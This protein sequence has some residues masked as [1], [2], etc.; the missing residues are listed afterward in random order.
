MS[1]LSGFEHCFRFRFSPDDAYLGYFA[2]DFDH[3]VQW[4][5]FLTEK[6][7][8]ETLATIETNGCELVIG[9]DAYFPEETA[10]VSNPR[11]ND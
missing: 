11:W 1:R 6:I 5:T 9:F 8:K 10:K 7:K 2:D 3:Y 4:I